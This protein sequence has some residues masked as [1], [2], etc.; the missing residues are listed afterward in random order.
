MSLNLLEFKRK[1]KYKHI[2]F[3]S[4]IQADLEKLGITIQQAQS[5]T[6]RYNRIAGFLWVGFFLFFVGGLFF[7]PLFTLAVAFVVSG[8]VLEMLKSKERGFLIPEERYL[9]PQKLLAKVTR[10]MELEPSLHLFLD[11][12]PVKAKHKLS[13][14]IPDPNRAKWKIDRYADTWLLLEGQFLDQTEFTLTLS[15]FNIEKYGWKRGSSGKMKHKRKAK[16]KGLTLTLTL[17]FLR[18]K[19]GAVTLLRES[20]QE[21]LQFPATVQ[22]KRF[23]V[24]DR[25]VSLTLKVPPY[26]AS[27][28]DVDRV[29]DLITQMF[30]NLYH[31]LTLAKELSQVTSF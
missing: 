21:A 8:L 14:T 3:A 16:P 22:V 6:S 7:P 20:L 27:N 9:L 19:Y 18:K 10:D 31:V 1:P 29:E 11:C 28:V 4:Q 2:G 23:K 30:L 24:S 26:G 25:T 15:E 13:D 17:R 5:K 12:Y